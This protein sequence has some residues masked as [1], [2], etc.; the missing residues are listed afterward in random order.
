MLIWV[1][2]LGRWFLSCE[3]FTYRKNSSEVPKK[4]SPRTIASEAPQKVSSRR[5]SLETPQKV[6][7][8]V[9]SLEVP[10]RTS[11]RA[12]RELK[13]NGSASHAT[14]SLNQ[15]RTPKK[16]KSTKVPEHRSLRSPVSEV[17]KH[18]PLHIPVYLHFPSFLHYLLSHIIFW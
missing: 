1:I 7:A 8:R 9:L 14:A 15:T 5:A 18:W 12:A 2:L 16:D 6:S 4:T 3:W 11:L 10:Q 17:T 13:T